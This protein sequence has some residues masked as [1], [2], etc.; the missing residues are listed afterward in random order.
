M[1]NSK[2]VFLLMILTLSIVS[3][4]GCGQ[5]GLSY[6]E[7][8]CVTSIETSELALSLSNY[9][10]N[11]E[12]V[13]CLDRLISDRD[14]IVAALYDDNGDVITIKERAGQGTSSR[15]IFRLSLE[16]GEEEE[17]STVAHMT[18][19]DYQIYPG[20]Y[21]VINNNPLIIYDFNNGDTI[22]YSD[23]YTEC[24][25]GTS[26]RQIDGIMFYR[27]KDR[28]LYYEDVYTR[29]VFKVKIDDLFEESRITDTPTIDMEIFSQ[30]VIQPG[31]GMEYFTVSGLSNDETFVETMALDKYT[32]KYIIVYYD[33]ESNQFTGAYLNKDTGYPVMRDVDYYHT[34]YLD[35]SV[36]EIKYVFCDHTKSEYYEYDTGFTVDEEETGYFLNVNVF[37][38]NDRSMLMPFYSSFDDGIASIYVWNYIE[39]DGSP[40][41]ESEYDYRRQ[42]KE[43][44]FGPEKQTTDVANKVTELEE[45][46]GIFIYTGKEVEGQI[47]AYNAQVNEEPTS[48]INCLNAIDE[49]LSIYPEGFI[50]EISDNYITGISFYLT[51][52]LPPEDATTTIAASACT[53]ES[54]GYEC[55][56]IDVTMSN[57]KE[58]ATH[59]MCHVIDNVIELMGNTEQWDNVWN[60]CNPEKFEYSRDYLNY[61]GDYEYTSYDSQYWEN[62]DPERVYFFDDYA[63]TY[64]TEDRARTMEH[65]TTYEMLDLCYES[66]HMQAKVKTYID[67][68]TKNFESFKNSQ[69]YLWKETYNKLMETGKIN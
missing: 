21:E 9:A 7:E 8:D 50:Q 25:T 18:T 28:C 63:K 38:M 55:I 62:N 69:S 58:N 59:E 3:L 4:Y 13:Y 37:C 33:L 64:P 31:K 48:Q 30:K 52:E 61:L 2:I 56:A 11:Q 5:K 43:V 44:E 34:L 45:K 54:G 20:S 10:M 57:C 27:N 41:N 24:I 53:F 51:G 22:L 32:N 36:S 19:D 29:K 46:Y 16:T 23:D 17:L 12:G 1:R 60:K 65:F 66:S 39:T 26:S 6:N 49:V 68:M 40:I 42:F 47:P 67:Y 14:K 15:S 35:D